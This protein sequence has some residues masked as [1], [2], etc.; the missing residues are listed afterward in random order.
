MPTEFVNDAVAI[1]VVNRVGTPATTSILS[2][3]EALVAKLREIKFC[4][5]CFTYPHTLRSVEINNTRVLF[6][7]ILGRDSVS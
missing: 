3:D 1:P 5:H 6:D 7:C 4:M 2:M